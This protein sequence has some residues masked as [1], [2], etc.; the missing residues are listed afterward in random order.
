ME[1]RPRFSPIDRERWPRR[2]VS[3]HAEARVNDCKLW[4][5]CIC[6]CVGEH[7]CILYV[8]NVHRHLFFDFD[9]A[10]GEVVVIAAG[11]CFLL[12]L[13]ISFCLL[14]AF[15]WLLVFGCKERHKNE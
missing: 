9:F 10:S 15:W 12:L 2:G 14:V 4:A 11:A 8:Q 3:S 7:A 1:W 6:V 13:L 5:F